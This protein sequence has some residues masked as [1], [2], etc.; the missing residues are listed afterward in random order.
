MLYKKNYKEVISRL[1]EL[2]SGEGK[3]RIYAVMNV[4]NP[5]LNKYSKQTSGGE[6]SYPNLDERIS[7]WNSYCSHYADLNDD[8]IP[9]SYLTELDEGLYGGLLGGEVRFLNFPESGWLSSMTVP[10]W[11]D[12]SHAMKLTL[13]KPG[14]LWYDRMMHQMK[15]FGLASKGKYGCSH[16]ICIDV[17]NL[18][19]ELRGGSNAYVDVIEEPEVTRMVFDFSVELNRMVQDAYFNTVGLFE[20]GTISNLLQ[21]IPGRI[22]SESVDPYHM[23]GQNM[24]EEAGR[25][26]IERLMS[27]YDGAAVHIHA[28]A[29]GHIL[30]Y[31]STLKNLKAIALLDDPYNPRAIDSLGTL[32]LQCGSIPLV[33]VTIKFCEFLDKLKKHQLPGNVLYYVSETPS[34]DEAN[35]AMDAVRLY[36]V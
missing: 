14:N 28:N 15:M 20:G 2:Y 4:P 11:E 31:V 35:R 8:S 34:V 24:F 22:L 6:V 26:Y 25:E 13:P 30:P 7:F 36:R 9:C 10:F 12:L 17:L 23:T 29:Y 19:F 16:L 18:L 27:Y 5:A 21:W 1:S 32:I 33:Y 3:D